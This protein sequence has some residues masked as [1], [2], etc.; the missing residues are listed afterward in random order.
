MFTPSLWRRGLS[1]PTFFQNSDMIF[2]VS[3]VWIF[4]KH[5]RGNQVHM[6]L[7]LLCVVLRRLWVVRLTSFFSS[8]F[9]LVSIT[10][11][12]FSEQVW[13]NFGSPA[14]FFSSFLNDFLVRFRYFFLLFSNVSLV[15]SAT[16]S[17]FHFHKWCF[18]VLEIKLW[19]LVV[20]LWGFGLTKLLY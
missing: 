14:S 20:I 19:F 2:G 4:V 11:R 9:V 5:C 13:R 6:P 15:F 10:L 7:D 12:G 16:K 17:V 1:T 8:L 3:N 18:L